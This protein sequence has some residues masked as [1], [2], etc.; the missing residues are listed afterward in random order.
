MKYGFLVLCSLMAGLCAPPT[1]TDDTDGGTSELPSTCDGGATIAD[2]QQGVYVDLDEVE[3]PCAVVT[4]DLTA[5]GSGFFLQDPGGGEWGGIYVYLYGGMDEEELDIAIGDLVTVSAVVSEYKELTEL[6]IA[7]A[8][9]VAVIGEYPVT[10]DPVDCG[11]SDWEPWEGGL[12]SIDGLEMTSWPD[13]YGQV[14]TSC[15]GLTLDDQFFDYNGGT[16]AVCTPLV[17]PLT[18]SYGA[19]RILPRDEADMEACTDPEAVDASSIAEMKAAGASDGDYV[20]LEGVVITTTN[21][22][23]GELFFIQDQGGGENSGLVVYLGYDDYD[24][25]IGNVIDIQGPLSVYYDL[26]E[27][28]PT[29]I[30]D[31]GST[32]TPTPDV[33][34]ASPADW[35]TWEGAL[36]TLQDLEIVAEAEYGEFETNY[37]ININDLFFE[38]STSAGAQFASVTGVIDYAYGEY[39]LEPRDANDF[40]Q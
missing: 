36:V 22:P 29:Q 35:E 25:V 6:T 4:S 2:V 39:K 20:N 34:T 37:G 23:D 8:Y 3:I 11:T 19:Y 13:N 10:V 33:L 30:T 14:E 21:T 9:D 16:G 27:I 38:P 31:T 26:L 15:N 18:Y 1:K 32:A 24:A 40:V 5:T 17:G 12:I 28:A 7:T